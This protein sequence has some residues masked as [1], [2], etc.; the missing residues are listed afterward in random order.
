MLMHAM[1]VQRLII[2]CNKMDLI[3]GCIIHHLATGF[4]PFE[5]VKSW[6]REKILDLRSDFAAVFYRFKTS[7]N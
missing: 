2:V 4:N 6:S 1:G 3:M 5:W 7:C